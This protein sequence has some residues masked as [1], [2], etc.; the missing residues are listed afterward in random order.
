MKQTMQKRIDV[1]HHVIPE[2]Y[3]QAM[4]R[5]GLHDPIP[6]VAYPHWDVEADLD[7][8]DRYGIGTAVVSITAPGVAFAE[9]PEAARIARATNDA[10]AQL[11]ADHPGRYGA[12]AL[13]PLPDVDAAL[14][15]IDYALDVLGLDGVGLFTNHRGTYLGDPHFDRL[16]AAIAERD[17]LVHIHPETPTGTD[18]PSFGL[19]PSLYE[20]TFDTTRMAANLLYSGTLDRHPGLRLILSHAGGTVPF[21]AKRLTYATTINPNLRD[22][23]PRDVLGSLR[24]LYYD[25]AMSANRATLAAL[26]EFV[27]SDHILFGTDYPFMPESATA[28]SVTGIREFFGADEEALRNVEHDSAAALLPRLAKLSD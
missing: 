25:T 3:R 24:N 2:V 14:R 8:M 4:D 6:G 13:M 9:G 1:H 16:F 18:Q 22:R 20:F 19:P 27:S 11:I 17:A 10:L 5:A 15:E 7:L 28:E 12:F 26:S 23:E 21:L